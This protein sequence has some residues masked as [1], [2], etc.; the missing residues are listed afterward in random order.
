MK[1]LRCA[2]R[3]VVTGGGGGIRTSHTR[4]PYSLQQVDFTAVGKLLPQCF[5][6]APCACECTGVKN[7]TKKIAWQKGRV[8]TL[9]FTFK[10]VSVK[11][12]VR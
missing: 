5:L 10:L 11:K 4:R 3:T 6:G 7:F 9:Q 2:R 1:R 8:G 12:R